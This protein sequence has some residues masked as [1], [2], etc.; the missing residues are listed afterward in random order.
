MENSLGLDSIIFEAST[1]TKMCAK[2]LE[3]LVEF[4]APRSKLNKL[5]SADQA[6]IVLEE[7]AVTSPNSKVKTV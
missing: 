7:A 2:Q 5:L 3:N 1:V 6:A 4:Q